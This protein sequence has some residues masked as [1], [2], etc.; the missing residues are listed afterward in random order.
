MEEILKVLDYIVSNEV[1]VCLRNEILSI[2]DK[3]Y[4]NDPC[5]FYVKALLLKGYT[6]AKEEEVYE[7]TY[8]NYM[9]KSSNMGCKQAQYIIANRLYEKKQFHEAVGLYKKSAENGYAPSQWCFGIDTFNGIEN[10]VE[11]NP[12]RGI[13]YIEYS[14]GQLYEYAIEFLIEL[15][16]L[17]HE[18]IEPDAKKVLFYK[19]SLKWA[20]V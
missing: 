17:G 12:T 3:E 15:Y 8:Y 11:A 5:Y 13:E 1:T 6:N 20:T 9:L 18:E 16:S 19:K 14:A 2:L 7:K 4:K 10:V